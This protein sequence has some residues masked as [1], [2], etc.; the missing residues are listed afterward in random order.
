V[1]RITDILLRVGSFVC[2]LLCVLCP[3][4]KCLEGHCCEINDLLCIKQDVKLYT[5]SVS[6]V[7]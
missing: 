3:V 6:G 4:F 5:Y 2:F 7:Q 1:R